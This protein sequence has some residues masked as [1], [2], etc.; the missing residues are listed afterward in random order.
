MSE[1]TLQIN[2]KATALEL[3]NQVLEK[4]SKAKQV[5]SEQSMKLATIIVKDEAALA[6]AKDVVRE[7]K[8]LQKKVEAKRVFLKAPALEYGKAVDAAAKEMNLIIDEPIN[9]AEAK[10]L[11]F[12]KSLE[13]KRIAEL[14][15]IEE[16]RIAA[17]RE[18]L[19]EES[20]LKLVQQD[21]ANYGK[22]CIAE[23]ADASNLDH[24]KVIYQKYIK[25]FDKERFKLLLLEAEQMLAFIIEC[26]KTKKEIIIN[27]EKVNNGNTD[28]EPILKEL[29]SKFYDAATQY[30]VQIKQ[31]SQSIE[32]KTEA[33]VQKTEE[34]KNEILDRQVDL[35]KQTAGLRKV[36]KWEVE[37]LAMC[38]D[39]WVEHFPNKK[40]I[41]EWLKLNKET[42]NPNGESVK[43][44]R[45]YQETGLSGK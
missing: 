18:K 6:I 23:L 13:E 3:K 43:G 21:I 10:I 8:E 31:I 14:K 37:N 29:K 1:N 9:R 32:A 4:F 11:A 30:N 40:N 5:L 12:A 45:F 27:Q 24:L 39:E 36:W 33:I 35:S 28:V 34:K 38:P 22:Q 20:K 7:A 42:L 15:K 25:G 26:G 41:D 2:E 16:E 44:I 17:E 19:E